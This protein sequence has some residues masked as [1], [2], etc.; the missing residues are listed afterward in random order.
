[1]SEP[2]ATEDRARRL[3]IVASAVI[4]TTLL[5]GAIQGKLSRR[6]GVPADVTT[7]GER[8]ES[9]PGN[10]LVGKDGPWQLAENSRLE[11][12]IANILECVGHLKRTYVHRQ[13]G[14][15]VN[16]A[17][18]LGPPGPIAVHTPEICYSARD[19]KFEHAR[20]RVE[21]PTVEGRTDA[22][23]ALTLDAKNPGDNRLRVY[24]AWTVGGPWQA[25]ERPR[26]QFSGQPCLYKIQLACPAPSVGSTETGDACRRFLEA[27][28][29][30]LDR[31]LPHED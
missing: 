5:V 12:A 29:P 3:M 26:F 23:W 19:Y 24:Y 31:V 25:S 30:A 14:E 1:M 15:T 27:F 21:V 11:P 7:L 4:G 2:F 13:T 9:L 16:V 6:W 17:V 20:E 18:M 10:D 8:L 28:V 22:F